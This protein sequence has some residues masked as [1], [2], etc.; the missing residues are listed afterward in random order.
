MTR[1]H[2][3]LEIILKV[4]FDYKM[5]STT[6]SQ[7]DICMNFQTKWY[8]IGLYEE[9]VNSKIK[10]N[11]LEQLCIFHFNNEKKAYQPRQ[12]FSQSCLIFLSF[13]MS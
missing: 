4:I 12:E 6:S 3:I 9:E 1:R 11:Y 5:G 13:P 10:T 8:K 7:L 2:H